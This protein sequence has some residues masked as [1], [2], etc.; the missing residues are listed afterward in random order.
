[1]RIFRHI[2]DWLLLALH[3]DVPCQSAIGIVW[4]RIFMIE[5]LKFGL[6][7]IYNDEQY[8]NTMELKLFQYSPELTPSEVTYEIA[9]PSSLESL[10]I[11]HWMFQ[12]Q[13]QH[14]CGGRR[15]TKYVPPRLLYCGGQDMHLVEA[16]T[17]R[18]RGSNQAYATL[19]HCWGQA[20]PV[21]VLTTENCEELL[22]KIRL[23]SLSKTFQDA[24]LVTQKLGLEYLW[25]DSLCIIQKGELH[26]SDWQR[27]I[28]DMSRIYENCIINIAAS[29]SKDSHGGLFRSAEFAYPHIID[30]TI[31]WNK[32]R[33]VGFDS[34]IGVIYSS[35]NRHIGN[36]ALNKRGWVCQERLMSP[37]TIHYD[38]F[39]IYWECDKLIASNA[40]PNGNGGPEIIKV[41]YTFLGG[42][43]EDGEVS[44][45][46]KR[47]YDIVQ[48]Y[49]RDHLT[50]QTDRLA[51]IAAI[52]Q[53]VNEQYFNDTYV[54]G[55]FLGH[56]C[57]ALCFQVHKTRRGQPNKTAYVAPTWSWASRD[58]TFWG[59]TRFEWKE[60]IAKLL[61]F[62]V[63]LVDKSNI[64]G[65]IRDASLTLKCAKWKLTPN[66]EWSY[67]SKVKVPYMLF[68]FFK[69]QGYAEARL[70]WDDI[71]FSLWNDLSSRVTLLALAWDFRSHEVQG[72]LVC[73]SS[74][75][76]GTS[77][78]GRRK[79]KAYVRIGV[80]YMDLRILAK[81]AKETLFKYFGFR[82]GTIILV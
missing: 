10:D 37:R 79:E 40:F 8:T 50:N 75:D 2:N 52:A 20:P 65:Q 35:E 7:V 33:S 14:S 43:I 81:G 82:E 60:N 55:V 69:T 53:K 59:N 49:S 58:G 72:I 44:S 68:Q 11:M 73:P 71:S 47:W 16:E 19:S 36:F 38:Q 54:A 63:D 18:N 23:E 39:Q 51:A 26:E 28:R 27:H 22:R 74:S 6:G 17:M 48:R 25:I 57:H 41:P 61:S 3:K 1:M 4:K 42:E 67:P 21:T 31:K 24:V 45:A 46:E 15:D 30:P 62:Y 76:M 13:T 56:F 29:H 34:L 64:Y 32:S 12:C 78:L 80:W 66:G 9:T 70:K 5:L 77:N